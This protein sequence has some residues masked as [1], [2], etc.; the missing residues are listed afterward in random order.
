M[1]SRRRCGANAVGKR[2]R[3]GDRKDKEVPYAAG[4]RVADVWP[5]TRLLT[6]DGLGHQ[7]ILRDPGVVDEVTRLV[8]G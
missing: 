3:V 6:T 8:A 5:Q 4:A 1:S 2:R 7:R